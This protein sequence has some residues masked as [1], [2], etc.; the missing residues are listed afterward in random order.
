M[1]Q[2]LGILHLFGDS[3][4]AISS[5]SLKLWPL[6]LLEEWTS[7]WKIFISVSPPFCKYTIPGKILKILKKIL[8]T[9]NLQFHEKYKSLNTPWNELTQ[10]QE[11]RNVIIYL[12]GVWPKK[13][14]GLCLSF[15][16]FNSTHTQNTSIVS[17]HWNYATKGTLGK[18]GSCC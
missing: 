3:K 10:S 5:G 9:K 6:Q 12:H 1:D 14:V 16:H 17:L 18:A 2:S 7:R 13:S 11:T 15:L 8:T 4:K